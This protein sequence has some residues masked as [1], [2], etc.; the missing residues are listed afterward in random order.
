MIVV[1]GQDAALTSVVGGLVAAPVIGVPTSSGYGAAFAGLSALLAMLT[2]CA[3]GV[4][5]VNIDDGFGAGT[6]AA[7]IAR[8][9]GGAPSR[10]RPV[11]GSRAVTRLAYVDAIGG[12]A[13]DMLLGALLDAGAD[14]GR[15]AASRDLPPT[16]S[17]CATSAPR[18]LDAAHL[19][20]RPRHRRRPAHVDPWPTHPGRPTRTDPPGHHPGPT[21]PTAAGL[22]VRALLDRAG[23][24]ERPLARAHAIF[25]ALAEAR[26]GSTAS[27]P[28]PSQFHE[29]GGLDS[30]GDIAGS[31][32]ALEELGVDELV[33]SPLPVARGLRRGRPR[34]AAAPGA[35]DRSS[36]SGGARST[37][38]TSTSS[39]SRRPAP[40]SSPRSPAS[41][42]RSR[43]CA[44]RR[45]ATEPAP[46]TSPSRPN[47]VRLLIGERLATAAAGQNKDHDARGEAIL[48]ETNLDDLS[49]ELVPDAVEGASP[50][51]ALDVWVV[52]RRDEEVPAGDRL[53]GARPTGRRAARW[54]ARS[55]ARRPPSACGSR[56]SAGGSSSAAG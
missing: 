22:D 7:R 46:A 6:I 5:V 43:R 21:R 3:A 17:S 19:H 23:L 39:S 30:I 31:R 25:A 51:G 8:S 37:G 18:D 9:A 28:R 20:V 41:S 4:A 29:V 49:P 36:S 47:L 10:Q 38:W 16:G 15:V 11:A 55:S 32:V 50:P 1:A 27:R 44:S 54:S 48:I 45:S 56:R 52:P 13:G 34:P 12:L 24:A 42:G 14:L 2:S 40:P 35:G 33:C 53:L 26:A